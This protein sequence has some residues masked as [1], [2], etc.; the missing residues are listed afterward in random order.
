L[1]TQIFSKLVEDTGRYVPTIMHNAAEA[2]E[3]DCHL[4]MAAIAD[5][6]G[7]VRPQVDDSLE[8]DITEGRHPV[9]ERMMPVGSSMSP[10]RCI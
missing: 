6:Y 9:I 2:A 5:D 1:E 10:I 7:Y 3:I 4:A 8:L